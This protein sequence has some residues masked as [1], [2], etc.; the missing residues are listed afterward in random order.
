MVITGVYV[1]AGMLELQKLVMLV[2]FTY[3]STNIKT[4]DHVD[5]ATLKKNA[6]DLA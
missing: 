2:K 6:I 3:K 1:Q 5:L 4:L